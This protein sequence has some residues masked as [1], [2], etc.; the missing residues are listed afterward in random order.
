MRYAELDAAEDSTI[1][2]FSALSVPSVPLS[3]LT[4][5][6]SPSDWPSSSA[7]AKHTL[8]ITSPHVRTYTY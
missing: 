6:S 7:A 1:D 2:S 5:I 8:S 4:D 3:S